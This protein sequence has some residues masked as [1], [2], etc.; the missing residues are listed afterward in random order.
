MQR[1]LGLLFLRV[2]VGLMMA[3]G[4]GLGKVQAVLAGDFDF[5]DP[6]GI[7]PSFSLILA[8][9][10]EFV[11]SLLVVLGFKT[12]WVAI[13]VVVTMLVAAFGY[14]W[15]DPWGRKEFA[16]LYAIPFLTLVF[17]GAGRYSVDGKMGKSR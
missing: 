11:C 3:F 8:A 4:H 17:T 12:R 2:T 14:H 15:A 5:A 13:P 1:D 6:I 9:L 16:L 10:A 7:G